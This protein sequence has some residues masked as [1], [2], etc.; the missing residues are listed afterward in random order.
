MLER[1]C[2]WSQIAKGL[3]IDF[4][5]LR[6]LR[7]EDQELAQ[8]VEETL[9]A[10]RAELHG[11]LYEQA[12]NGRNIIAAMFLLKTRHGYRENT[13]VDVAVNGNVIMLPAPATPEDYAKMFAQAGSPA[14]DTEAIPGSVRALSGPAGVERE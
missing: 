4:G 5:T 8:M 9:E 10:E 3:R 6:R 7:D 2:T 11:V 1:H 13:P 14:N 12:V